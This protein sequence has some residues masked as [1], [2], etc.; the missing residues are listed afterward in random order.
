LAISID[1]QTNVSCN[2][3]TNGDIT[4]DVT[5]AVGTLSYQITSPALG[6]A[7]A[8][9]TF[10]GLAAGA[11]TFRASDATLV[12]GITINATITEPSQ[13]SLTA[14]VTS[15]YN[16]AQI[17]CAGA[18]DGVADATASGGTGAFGF[19]WTNGQTNAIATGLI[20]GVHCVTATDAN[21]C[22][23]STC[24]TLVEPSAVS[25]T[26]SAVA[27]TCFG[28]DNGSTAAVAAG[29]IGA[30]SFVWNNNETT[31]NM[32]DLFAGVY[33]VT[34]SDANNWQ[35]IWYCDGYTFW[36]CCSL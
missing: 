3:G 12:C 23:I 25:V 7:Q 26:A 2:A 35:S 27:A 10:T 33:T 1:N 30:Y 31:A 9:N 17:S 21:G 4:L 24:V 20:A 13:V 5:G 18:A 8:S 14:A 34:A 28:L 15:N 32:A 11:Y 36:G 29:G 16:A 6:V 22:N 19:V